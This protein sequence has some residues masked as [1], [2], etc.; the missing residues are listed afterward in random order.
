[1]LEVY[2]NLERTDIVSKMGSCFKHLWM[3]YKAVLFFLTGFACLLVGSSLG[4][5]CLD[6]V[7][8]VLW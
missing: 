3:S 2:I 8:N 6:A 5:L 1:M 4:V 7:A